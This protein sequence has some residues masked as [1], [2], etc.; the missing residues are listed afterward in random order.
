[1]RRRATTNGAGTAFRIALWGLLLAPVTGCDRRDELQ[2]D[3]T[4]DVVVADRRL[5]EQEDTLLQQRGALQRKRSSVRDKRAALLTRKLAL[6][7]QDDSAKEEIAKEE[8]ELVQLEARLVKQE[9]DLNKKLESLVAQKSG[10][11]AK[12]GKSDEQ[13]KAVLLT[14]REV[15]LSQ[16]ERDL[17]RR[18]SELG[19]REKTLAQ[20]E[21]A[22][23]ERQ[24]K[25]CPTTRSTVI[26]TTVPAIGGKPG[27]G[28]RRSDVEP[29]YR[30]ALQLMRKRGILTV[31]LPAGV[32]NLVTETRHAVSSGDYDRAKY[33]VDQLLDAVR[34]IKIDRGF[35]GVKIDR[36]AQAI[37]RRPPTGAK[38]REVERLFQQAT[39]HYGD[40]RDRPN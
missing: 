37:R 10:L 15:S 17:A 11:V 20:R 5:A 12:L 6:G 35:I 19:A 30:R 18:E 1:M 25:L 39:A 22:F 40:G 36:L 23:A 21:Q 14:R 31:D 4:L 32:D 27:K 33:S 13:A 28:Y 16:R 2:Q 7:E 34:G 29:L 26:Q 3:E 8:S 38:K 24:A 9:L